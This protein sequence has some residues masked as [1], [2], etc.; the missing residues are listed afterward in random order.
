[1]M[2]IRKKKKKERDWS[3]VADLASQ[4]TGLK[5]FRHRHADL[6]SRD[7]IGVLPGQL[8]ASGHKKLGCGSQ[9]V[10]CEVDVAKVRLH[11]KLKI[12]SLRYAVTELIAPRVQ[13]L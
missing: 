13:T 11:H 5:F 8:P 12:A 4:R 7:E 9:C 3:C 2:K 10:V 6:K 1:M